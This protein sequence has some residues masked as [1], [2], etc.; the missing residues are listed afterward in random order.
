MYISNLYLYLYLS[1]LCLYLIY[2][3]S[4]IYLYPYVILNPV[5][6]ASEDGYMTTE[7]WSVQK[8]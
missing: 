4:N 1:P 7:T 5:S 6:A 8:E 2:I 3:L